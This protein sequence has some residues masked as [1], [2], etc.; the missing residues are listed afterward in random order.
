MLRLKDLG[1]V[2][3]AGIMLAMATVGL[4]LLYMM[5]AKAQVVCTAGGTTTCFVASKTTGEAPIATT[6]VWNVVGATSCKAAGV[7]AWSGDVPTSGTRNLTGVGVKMTLTL[8]C[9]APPTAGKLRLRFNKPTQNTDNTPLTNLGGYLVEWGTAPGALNQS[10]SVPLSSVETLTSTVADPFDSAYNVT[11]LTAGT[12]F[13]TLRAETTGC[14]PSTT[15]TCY[16]S[17]PT[18]PP[19]SVAVTTTPGGALPQQV[20]VL[21]PY[22]VPKPP[23]NLTVTDPNASAF[24][25]YKLPGDILTAHAFGVIEPTSLCASEGQQTVAG[26]LY[27]RVDRRLVQPNALAKGPD[28]WVHEPYAK[29]G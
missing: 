18:A 28:K 6:L 24:E 7:A 9:V 2:K 19:V 10:A 5:Q 3:L 22:K 25:I 12:W 26:I 20:V 1:L 16:V 15:V 23:T 29:C 21:D 14:F 8:D 4:G 17:N 11:G 13:A 27:S